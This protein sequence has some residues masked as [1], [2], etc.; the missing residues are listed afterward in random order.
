M[1]ELKLYHLNKDQF[2]PFGDIIDTKQQLPFEI[3]NGNCFRYNNLAKLSFNKGQAGISLFKS[4][5]ITLPYSFNFMEKHPLG[6][7]AFI[8]VFGCRFIVIVANE[9]NG[10]PS[11]PTAFITTH[12]QGV[13]YHKDIWHGVLAPIDDDAIFTVID[14]I[15]D[16]NNLE[17]YTFDN[18]FQLNL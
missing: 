12:G 13:N 15:G 6:S 8:P 11:D 10:L 16:G 2:E 14:W 17:T 1:K 4:K 3:N 5:K 7:Q 18:W 9:V